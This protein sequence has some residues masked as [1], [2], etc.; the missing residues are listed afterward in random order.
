MKKFELIKIVSEK[1][2]YNGTNKS[3]GTPYKLYEFICCVGC[4]GKT[5]NSV[6]IK[7]F[8]ERIANLIKA[9]NLKDFE[10]EKKEHNGKISYMINTKSVPAKNSYYS[11]KD[12]QRISFSKFSI[13]CHNCYTLAQMLNKNNP[14]N[15]FEKI[16]GVASILV[17]FSKKES[18]Q[19]EISI[20]NKRGAA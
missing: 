15:I 14:D 19:N 18:D 1:P 10:V 3:T 11:K 5:Y 7:T 4:D 8:S 16:L 6:T 13:L 17:D 20:N 9:G 2:V 12:Q